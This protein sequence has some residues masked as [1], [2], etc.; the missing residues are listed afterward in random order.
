MRG[1]TVLITGASSGIGLEAARELARS[2]AEVLLVARD[3]ERGARA[4]EDVSAAAT[5]AA[6]ALLMADL[7]SQ[8][9]VRAL[10]RAVRA[11][12]PGLDVLINNA[13]GIFSRREFT[14]DGIEK[15]FATNQLAPFLLTHLLQDLMFG[16]SDA[17]IVNV[18]ADAPFATLDLDNLQSEKGHF[19][20]GAYFRSKLAGT[21]FTFDLAERLRARGVTVN[22]MSPGPT[23]TRFGD[24]LTG[25]PGLFPR[26]K[27]LFPGPQAGGKA[28]AYLASAPEV[29]GVTGAFFL[30]RRRMK[31]KPF[32]RDPA[33]A[34]RLWDI[35]AG[36]VRLDKKAAPS[37]AG[38]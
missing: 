29:A 10:A 27:A 2:G 38:G 19:F 35:C 17:R 18:V 9:E 3:P 11:R 23:R 34:A 24:D 8:S 28:L 32:L 20:L 25:L 1:K 37:P 30:R 26:L 7:S 6:P 12:G 5:G 14:E 13:A 15:T 21:V 16:R 22:C 36:L 4:L 31:T 33:V